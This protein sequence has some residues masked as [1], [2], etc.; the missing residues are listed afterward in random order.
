MT[1][2]YRVIAQE[3]KV[4]EL[5]YA[6]HEVYYEDHQIIHWSAIPIVLYAESYETLKAMKDRYLL[7]YAKP[8]LIE[9]ELLKDTKS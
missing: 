8:V 5:I 3:N 6:V 1:W 2:N 9:S 7:A 4:G